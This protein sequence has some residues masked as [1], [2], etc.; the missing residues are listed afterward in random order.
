MRRDIN[1]LAVLAPVQILRTGRRLGLGESRNWSAGDGRDG[2]TVLAPGRRF[3]SRKCGNR[4]AWD[5]GD[6]FAEDSGIGHRGDC[7]NACSDVKWL[8][9]FFFL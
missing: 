8:S 5:R 6:R 3:R 9:F 4:S 1:D 2:F 7:S